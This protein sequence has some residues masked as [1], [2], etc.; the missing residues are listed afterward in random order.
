MGFVITEFLK[1]PPLPA[2]YQHQSGHV[3]LVRYLAAEGARVEP[4][5]SIVLIEN[6][7]ASFEVVCEV[8]ARLAKNLLDS[9]P[10]MLI[11]EGSDLAFLVLEPDWLPKDGK[12][13]SLKHISDK[14]IKPRP[15][16][17]SA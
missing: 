3:E 10:G 15:M 11:E 1:M 16:R 9:L 2:Q 7:W 6:W 4:G 14:R 13:S 8:H 5:T 12:F 17:D